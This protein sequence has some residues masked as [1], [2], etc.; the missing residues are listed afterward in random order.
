MPRLYNTGQRRPICLCQ[1]NHTLLVRYILKLREIMEQYIS[2]SDDT[3]LD[4]VALPEGFIEDQTELTIS[5][6]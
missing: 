2:F 5:R 6:E 1:V 3:I 4:S